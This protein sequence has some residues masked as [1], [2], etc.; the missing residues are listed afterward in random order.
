M[1]LS[2]VSFFDPCIYNTQNRQ[3]ADWEGE[4]KFS[5]P[6]STVHKYAH[7]IDSSFISYISLHATHLCR[8]EGL[9]PRL[10][11]Q[12]LLKLSNV[13][14]KTNVQDFIWKVKIVKIFCTDMENR[15]L[16]CIP[17][18]YYTCIYTIVLKC[19]TSGIKTVCVTF[20]KCEGN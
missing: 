8:N 5:S 20:Y 11:K 10:R 4:M 2:N 9:S 16:M 3:R 1:N 12:S 19:R 15:A 17:H 6:F 13:M 7:T 14:P 18:V